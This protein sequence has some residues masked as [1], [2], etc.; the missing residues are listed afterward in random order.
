MEYFLEVLV[1]LLPFIKVTLYIA[2][3]AMLLGL[4]FG[5]ILAAMKISRRRILNRIANIY[6]TLIR[7]TPVVVLLFLSYYGFPVLF[8]LFGIDISGFS[9]VSFSI[10]ALTMYSSGVLSE[11]IRPAYQSVDKGQYEAAVMSGL[12]GWQAIR[13]IILP[14]VVFV[15][16]PNFG[17]MF[18]AL[19]QESSLAFLIGVVD[20]MGQAKVINAMS[21]G[22]HIIAIYLAASLL[23]WIMSLISGKAVDLATFRMGRILR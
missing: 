21:Y 23:Y 16:L 2:V 5:S 11:I 1:K 4:L 13:I 19:I 3:A 14:Q 6:I 22:A 18:I 7:C 10:V 17:N 15:A 9:K 8:Q 12:T 20:I